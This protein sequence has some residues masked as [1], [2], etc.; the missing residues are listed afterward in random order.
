[1]D[2][3][4]CTYGFVFSKEMNNKNLS[5]EAFVKTLYNLFTDREGETT[6]VA[7]WTSYLQ[8]GHSREEVFHGFA[9]SV[10]FARL[11]AGYGIA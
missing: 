9:D 10:E 5:D 6:G 11:K 7:F 1:M 4:T 3:T 8:D 2:A